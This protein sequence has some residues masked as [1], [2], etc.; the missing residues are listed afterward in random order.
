MAR[1]LR[2]EYPGAFY[3]VM[4]RG[5]ERREI[6]RDPKDYE[7]FLKVLADV[8]KPAG[9]ICHSYCLMPNHYHL[10][11]ETPQ[12]NLSKIMQETNGRYTQYYNRRYKRVGPLFQGRYKAKLIDQDSYSLQLS[13]YIHLNPVKAKMVSRPEGWRWSSYRSFVGAT[14][15]PDFLETDWL[16]KQIGNQRREF[17]KFTMNGL[18]DGWDPLEPTGRGPVLGAEAF[19]ERIKERFVK[20]GRDGALTGLRELRKE[21]RVREVEACVKGLGCD[22]ERLRKKLRIYGLKRCTGL[23]LKEIGEKAGGMKAVAVSQAVRRL[24]A[25]ARRDKTV[26]ALIKTLVSNVKP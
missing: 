18:T 23:S 9:F 2:I 14:K 10:F 16:L 21:D 22:D 20:K 6:I 15:R 12:G 5:L 7:K 11:L 25:A 4:N 3:H 19:V 24:E 17:E 13:R 26:A 8:Q 1:P